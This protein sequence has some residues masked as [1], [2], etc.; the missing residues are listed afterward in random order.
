[1]VFNR[2][3]SL[4]DEFDREFDEMNRMVDRMFRD[5]R[6][7]DWG[8]LP[9]NQP[10]YYGVS[11]DV[12]PDGVPRVREFGNVKPG[13][14][15]LLEGGVREAFATAFLDE[16]KNQIRVTAEMPGVDKDRIQVEALED[17]LTIRGEGEDR[18]YE[19][20]LRLRAPVSPDS[21]K[22]H[23]KNGVLEVTLD[24]ARPV[25]PKGRKVPVE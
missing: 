18:R 21:A 14:H 6:S 13:S 1:M 19:K 10:V 20:T 17:S 9:A 2:R 3:S 15:G 4:F 12:G 8:R 5:F 25:K 11:V 16:D 7:F 24:L 22:A 23:F